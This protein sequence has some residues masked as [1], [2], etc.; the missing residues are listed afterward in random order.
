MRRG[1]YLWT[2]LQSGRFFVRRHGD[3]TSDVNS[4]E[5]LFTLRFKARGGQLNIVAQQR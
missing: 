2:P 1:G 3:E 4:Y 5:N